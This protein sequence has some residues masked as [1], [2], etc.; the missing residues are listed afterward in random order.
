MYLSYFIFA[1]SGL[2][3]FA[4]AKGKPVLFV[5][6]LAVLAVVFITLNLINMSLGE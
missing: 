4:F 6:T 2:A 1:L 3:I 5:I